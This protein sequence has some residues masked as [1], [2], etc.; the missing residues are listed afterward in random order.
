MAQATIVRPVSTWGLI[1]SL[2][3]FALM[4]LTGAILV[5]P[6]ATGAS[7]GA[8]A[9]VVYRLLIVR[10]LICHAH[11]RGVR[12][13]RA[14]RFEEAFAAFGRSRIWF[15]R[16]PWLDRHRGILLGTAV[17]HSFEVLARYNQAYCLARIGRTQEAIRHLDALLADVP[18]TGLAIELRGLLI[19]NNP[20]LGDPSQTDPQRWFEE[21][22]E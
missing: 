17:A 2:T 4:A 5:R 22:E 18:E 3:L 16:V 15:S 12:L 13:T 14:G 6:T 11:R 20:G 21:G 8:L 19:A 10:G 1:G 7:L 9:F